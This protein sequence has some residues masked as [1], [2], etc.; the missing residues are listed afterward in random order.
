VS[1]LTGLTGLGFG[2]VTKVNSDAQWVSWLSL[3]SA[4]AMLGKWVTGDGNP[5]G[6]DDTIRVCR[7]VG[8]VVA[9]VALVLLWLLAV[10][11][12]RERSAAMGPLAL[13]LG[14]AAVLGPS[15]Q[16]WY[17]LWGLTVAGLAVPARRGLL[18]LAAVPVVFTVMITPSGKGW[19][20]D[21]RAP[22]V[23]LGGAVVTAL[24]LRPGPR[25]RPVAQELAA[26]PP[27]RGR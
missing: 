27:R 10:R 25:S 12:P 23:V 2:W 7:T 14:L 19:E 18:A 1:A 9:V 6:L 3:P 8:E 20:S 11:R 4:A 13:A 21:W 24:V 15:V 5:R 26:A 17:Y 22:L 16:P